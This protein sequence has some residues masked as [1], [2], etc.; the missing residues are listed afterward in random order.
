MKRIPLSARTLSYDWPQ[1]IEGV[2]RKELDAKNETLSFFYDWE[3]RSF[4][5]WKRRA[6]FKVHEKESR[7]YRRQIDSIVALVRTAVLQLFFN[8]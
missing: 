2:R 6:A 8:H 5:S 3:V 7:R 4:E 1:L